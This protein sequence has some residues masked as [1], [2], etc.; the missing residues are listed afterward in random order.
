MPFEIPVKL[1]MLPSDQYRG[2]SPDEDPIRFYYWP[3]FGPLYRGRVE[4]C[5]NECI[6]GQRVLE[7]GYGSGISFLNLNEMYQ[8]IHGLDLLTDVLEVR[9][10]FEAIGIHPDLRNGNVLQMPYQGD[11]FDTVLLISILEHLQPSD[12]EKAFSEVKR[13]LK[14][15]GQVVYG[16]PVERPFMVTMFRLLGVD[17]RKFHFSTEKQIAVAAEKILRK[18]RILQMKSIPPIPGVVYEVGHFVKE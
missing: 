15:G 8:E 10:V 18:K 12:L 7:I 14:P 3:V 9:S 17:I 2:T 16:T 11:T 4:L 13:V 5:L 6:G 1:K